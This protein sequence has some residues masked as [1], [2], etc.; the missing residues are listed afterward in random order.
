[1]Y[2]DD[3]A[4]TVAKDAPDIQEIAIFWTV[5]YLNASAKCAY[6]RRGEGMYEMDMMWDSAF[7]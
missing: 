3:L 6:E 4:A 5:P 2:S 1:M 7:N